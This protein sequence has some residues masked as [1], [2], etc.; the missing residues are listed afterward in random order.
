M[1]LSGRTVVDPILVMDI[2]DV[3][4]ASIKPGR[5]ILSKL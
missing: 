5:A 4:D 3:F 1:T 2:E